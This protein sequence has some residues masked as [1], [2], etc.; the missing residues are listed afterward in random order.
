MQLNYGLL[1][2]RASQNLNI[3]RHRVGIDKYLHSISVL[4]K[5]I[6]RDKEALSLAQDYGMTNSLALL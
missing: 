3:P 2:T 1:K 4:K 6:M 5:F